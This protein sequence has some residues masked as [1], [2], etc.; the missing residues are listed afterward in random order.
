[1]L[2]GPQM[3]EHLIIGTKKAFANN[4]AYPYQKK[5]VGEETIC[6]CTKGSQRARA[7]EVLVLRCKNDTW[8]AYDTA[9]MADGTTLH[10]RQPVVRCI[11]TDIT[12]RGWHK[13]EI[14]GLASP[15]DD[16]LEA[17]WQGELWAET[18]VP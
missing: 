16:G 9:K 8:T 5:Q 7:G 15:T 13:W 6:V 18:R 3:P 17:D 14:N 10:C 4:Y 1:M 12:Q 11:G 2:G